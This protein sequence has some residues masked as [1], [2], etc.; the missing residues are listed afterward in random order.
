MAV[1]LPTV[2]SRDSGRVG[3]AILALA[4]AKSNGLPCAFAWQA[5]QVRAV[6]FCSPARRAAARSLITASGAYSLPA[7]WHDSQPTPSV[8][9]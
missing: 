6:T 8:S 7:P 9:S 3:W 5:A 2:A 1:R 4:T